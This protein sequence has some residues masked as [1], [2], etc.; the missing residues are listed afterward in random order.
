MDVE[1]DKKLTNLQT[2]METNQKQISDNIKTIFTYLARQDNSRESEIN[3]LRSSN[4]YNERVL[5]DFNDIKDKLTTYRKLFW[6]TVSGLV[7]ILVIFLGLK[8]FLP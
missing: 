3:R 2:I 4:Q 6:G 5:K 7:S 1:L 8:A